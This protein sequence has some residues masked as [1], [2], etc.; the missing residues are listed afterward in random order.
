[1][2]S[3]SFCAQIH[4]SPIR[5]A[6]V[7]RKCDS[8]RMIPT[9]DGTCV[10]NG[11]AI[12]ING[13][14]VDSAVFAIVGSI[15]GFMVL[16]GVIYLYIQYK[17]HKADE[18]WKVNFDELLF[19]DPVEV[20]GQGS[21]GVVLL[22]EYRGTK[23]AIKQAIKSKSGGSTKVGRA[24]IGR[25]SIGRNGIGKGDSVG[26]DGIVPVVTTATSIGANSVISCESDDGHTVESSGGDEANSDEANSDDIEGGKAGITSIVSA[27]PSSAGVS[28]RVDDAMS[29]GFLGAAARKHD[30]WAWLPWRKEKTYQSHF[31]ETILGSASAS[32]TNTS[33]REAFCPWFDENA[34]RQE[35]FCREM[36]VLSMLRHPR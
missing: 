5:V 18:V 17:N 12:E 30:K 3:P 35:E 16:T 25:S 4:D 31:K 6:V 7:D 19:D 2:F 14:C 27:D 28:K 26:N 34:R 22:A 32:K 10:C 15:L 11:G 36:R 33:F 1:M 13:D 23:V 9:E 24:S 8:A 20:I 29:F 21:F